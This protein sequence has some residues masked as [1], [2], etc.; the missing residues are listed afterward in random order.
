M[1]LIDHWQLGAAVA[2]AGCVAAQSALADCTCRFG[3]R[4]F[5]LGASVCLPT[6][7]GGR[8]AKCAMVLNN[9]SWNISSAPCPAAQAFPPP[10]M[11]GENNFKHAAVSEPVR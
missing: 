5:E 8:L 7:A 4:D 3:G 6:T 1:L 10:P 9:T 2:V 11:E